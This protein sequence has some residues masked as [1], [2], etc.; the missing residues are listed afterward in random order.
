MKIK[1]MEALLPL[2]SNKRDDQ[3]S[4]I[5]YDIFEERAFTRYPQYYID[6][7]LEKY[8]KTNYTEKSIAYLA[9]LDSPEM[10]ND[11]LFSEPI[12][13]LKFNRI[14]SMM[15]HIDTFFI[16]GEYYFFKDNI[17][18]P[19]HEAEL[20]IKIYDAVLE[21]LKYITVEDV[22]KIKKNII[23][24]IVRATQSLKKEIEVYNVKFN[25]NSNILVWNDVTTF[26]DGSKF[27]IIDN[28]PENFCTMKMGVSFNGNDDPELKFE[29]LGIFSEIFP[30]C[31]EYVLT[32]ISSFLINPDSK[33][34]KLFLGGVNS[35]KST[36]IKIIEI[37]FG[38]YVGHNVRDK[39]I[40]I[41]TPGQELPID[42]N[43]HYLFIEDC[44]FKLS[45]HNNTINGINIENIAFIPFEIKLN[46]DNSKQGRLQ[47]LVRKGVLTNILIKLC[48]DYKL[49]ELNHSDEINNKI[50][51]FLDS[52]KSPFYHFLKE[53]NT[54]DHYLTFMRTNFPDSKRL[55][56][57]EF[58]IMMEDFDLSTKDLS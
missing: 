6:K 53:N 41:L 13:L 54:Y 46:T 31:L 20:D 44:D 33:N 19:I 28:I 15:F 50:K 47:T 45:K 10:F 34:V 14:I 25:S 30:N 55:P 42:S 49:E 32:S 52:L 58:N 22:E 26:Y 37:L 4:E 18:K 56:E 39:R 43:R 57:R 11:W 1:E 36:I 5:L 51:C 17:L 2:L 23:Y 27:T 29:L 38:T 16:N 24:Y 12:N 21:N 40:C 9:R 48:L 7:N 3:V 35:C 8:K